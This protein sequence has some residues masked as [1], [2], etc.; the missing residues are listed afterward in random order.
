M[1]FVSFHRL[2]VLLSAQV[3]SSLTARLTRIEEQ[4]MKLLSIDE[5]DRPLL[6]QTARALR[7]HEKTDLSLPG[8][9][10]RNQVD[11]D[12][13]E[14]PSDHLREHTLSPQDLI[15]SAPY[16]QESSETAKE[17]PLKDLNCF[18]MPRYHM[19]SPG[20]GMDHHLQTN[21]L[22]MHFE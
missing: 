17:N 10:N 19:D 20:P 18:K 9:G 12:P 13:A 21:L 22:F 1:Q 5:K 15:P 8:N 7:P 6:E 3:A 4:L 2:K 11:P 16:C 14:Q